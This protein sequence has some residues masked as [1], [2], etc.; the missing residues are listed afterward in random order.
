MNNYDNLDELTCFLQGNPFEHHIEFDDYLPL[1]SNSRCDIN[2]HP[3]NPHLEIDKVFFE[4][5]FLNK[6]QYITYCIGAQFVVKKE[7][8]LRRKKEF[9]QNLFEDF[10]RE[11]I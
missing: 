9:Y 2:G 6:P 10:E 4:K 8:I 1:G 11:R 5:Y 3:Q 7:A